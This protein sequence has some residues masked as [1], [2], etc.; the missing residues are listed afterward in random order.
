LNNPLAYFW[1][2]PRR[3]G[4]LFFNA[5]VVIALLAWGAYTSNLPQDGL[6]GVPNIMLG[7]TGMG[8]LLAAWI[9][10]WLAWGVMVTRRQA[11]RSV[12][13]AHTAAPGREDA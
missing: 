13:A 12:A 3:T 9:V 6:V 7:Y 4:F 2:H 5:L 10:A 11:K 8:F 1:R